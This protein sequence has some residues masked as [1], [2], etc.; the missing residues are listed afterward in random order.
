LD[1]HIKDKGKMRVIELIVRKN[2]T[3][4][5]IRFP[6]TFKPIETRSIMYEET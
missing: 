6:L 3:T 1:H 2:G 5:E 4:P